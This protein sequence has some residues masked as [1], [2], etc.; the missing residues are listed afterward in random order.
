[1][2]LTKLRSLLGWCCVLN[3]GLILFYSIFF[4]FGQE[5]INALV[6]SFLHVPEE[7]LSNLWIGAI[8]LWK[9]LVIVFFLVP[10]IALRMMESKTASTPIVLP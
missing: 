4:L 6:S 7:G 5:W 3:F 1:M 10:Y 9:I 2:N 8:G